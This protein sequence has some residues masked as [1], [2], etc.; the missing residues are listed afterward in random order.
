MFLPVAWCVLS[1]AYT[2]EI[3]N[4]WLTDFYRRCLIAMRSIL[5]IEQVEI[6]KGEPNIAFPLKADLLS[7]ELHSEREAAITVMDKVMQHLEVADFAQEIRQGNWR[8]P[9]PLISLATLFT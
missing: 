5:S 7:V 4:D 2:F 3:L 1:P 6:T 9:G 8:H